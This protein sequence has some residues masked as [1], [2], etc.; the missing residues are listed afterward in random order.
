VSDNP[1][2]TPPQAIA[3][4]GLSAIRRYLDELDRND[5]AVSKQL[6]VVLVG[7]GGAGKTSF[8][9]ALAGRPNPRQH[10]DDSPIHLDLERI[11]LQG[12]DLSLYDLGGKASDAVGQGMF[13]TPTALY[14]FIV[15]ADQ[16]NED[17][18]VAAVLY[19]F[20]M[21]QS[22]VP[23]AVVQF[24]LSKIDLLKD[25]KVVDAKRA[26]LRLRVMDALESWRR[27]ARER[28]F[29]P[30]RVE[31]RVL[32][33]SVDRP[34]TVEAACD[35][36][37]ELTKRNPPLFPSVGQLVPMSFVQVWK[38]LG[39]IA[40]HGDDTRAVSALRAGCARM[41]WSLDDKRCS[42][43]GTYRS[44]DELE[45]LWNQYQ[46]EVPANETSWVD[47]A[48]RN[49]MST[50][51]AF[52]SSDG[53]ERRH[54]QERQLETSSS[55]FGDALGLHETQ[56]WILMY[57]G[58][59]Y[60]QPSF[61]AD[62]VRA[63]VAHTSSVQETGDVFSN[64]AAYLPPSFIADFTRP[65]FAHA[66]AVHDVY[67]NDTVK[68]I[69]EAKFYGADFVRCQEEL[70]HFVRHGVLS[71]RV[72]RV[73]WNKLSLDEC[74]Y[75]N[76]L[77]MLGKSGVISCFLKDDGEDETW[78]AVVPSRLPRQPEVG[79]WPPPEANQSEHRLV[80]EFPAGCP[81]GIPERFAAFAH[82]LGVTQRA[83]RVGAVVRNKPPSSPN[84][85]VLAGVLHPNETGSENRLVFVVRTGSEN[86]MFA[87]ELLRSPVGFLQRLKSELLL[88]LDYAFGFEC[89]HCRRLIVWDC[90]GRLVCGFCH[91]GEVVAEAL[92]PAESTPSDPLVSTID[93]IGKALENGETADI[94]PD[95][96]HTALRVARMLAMQGLGEGQRAHGCMII[97]A[98]VLELLKPSARPGAPPGDKSNKRQIRTGFGRFPK[99]SDFRQLDIKIQ[100]CIDN[101]TA[102][103]VL[104]SACKEDGAIVVDGVS[105]QLC[106]GSFFVFDTRYGNTE[107][108]SKNQ[109]GS[110]IAMQ[111][112]GCYVIVASEDVCVHSGI[113]PKAGACLKIYDRTN[114]VKKVP[115]VD[116]SDA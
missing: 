2:K 87:W 34:R 39:A 8:R 21:I 71:R 106:C 89:P 26:W 107:G 15:A 79:V 40:E 54:N 59:V 42:A 88:G 65:R 25:R 4:Q 68:A 51:E 18:F 12:L 67:S 116:A 115:V 55:V 80:V 43:D 13:F 38:F 61:V 94:C 62:L 44:R 7:D 113:E 85:R 64:I 30:L 33:L 112:G 19:H 95:I 49:L 23:H 110:S 90:Q 53:N 100:E 66:T 98:N 27:V 17:T 78:R 5:G 105:A 63:L 69:H 3:S 32:A 111:A 35:A 47:D 58:L 96:T 81:P 52:W 91:K 10:E 74:H 22:L 73:L 86:R 92:D 97:V 76:A 14:V 93:E 37:V 77:L 24:V 114:K 75:N 84:Y 31:E 104:C 46:E 20:A 108:G 48:R 109:A 6:K 82:R 60:L 9:N 56:G 50:L 29:A 45:A 70:V 102:K 1:L 16:A 28:S 36:I 83:W 72:V 57:C 11:N 41:L 101:D 103:R 99:M